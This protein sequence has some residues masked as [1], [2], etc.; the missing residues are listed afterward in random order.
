VLDWAVAIA[1]WFAAPLA[2]LHVLEKGFPVAGVI[3][4]E[5]LRDV[6]AQQTREVTEQIRSLL[7]AD[8]LRVPI[9]P[10]VGRGLPSQEIVRVLHRGRH[11]LLCIGNPGRHPAVENLVGGTATWVIQHVPCSVL[12]V[13][14]QAEAAV[15]PVAPAA[16]RSHV[17]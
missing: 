12:A 5:H 9:A 14:P 4:G 1:E 15:V 11:D 6:L 3:R 10:M 8:R 13:P 16:S 17:G 2:V 7:S